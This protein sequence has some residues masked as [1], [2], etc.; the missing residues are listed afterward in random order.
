[1]FVLL[2]RFTMIFDINVPPAFKLRTTMHF[3]YSNGSQFSLFVWLSTTIIKENATLRSS[4]KLKFIKIQTNM[5]KKLKQL[6][7]NINTFNFFIDFSTTFFCTNRSKLLPY[8]R[9]SITIAKKDLIVDLY[10]QNNC[11]LNLKCNYFMGIK[12]N[13]KINTHF[14]KQLFS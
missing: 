3:F 2:V 14:F 6:W 12:I 13:K 8:A 4:S 5:L 1:M 10:I 9:L 7:K 11:P